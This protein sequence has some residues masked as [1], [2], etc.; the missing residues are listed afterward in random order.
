MRSRAASERRKKILTELREL[1]K[2]RYVA[3]FDIAVI[4][5]GLGDN[6]QALAWLEKAYDDRSFFLVSL[7]VDPR[8]DHL[9]AEPAFRAL[10]QRIGLRQNRS[11]RWD[12]MV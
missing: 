12:S 1:S 8:F 2:N 7:N 9:R 6:G 4:H 5:A 3:A 10:V 11:N